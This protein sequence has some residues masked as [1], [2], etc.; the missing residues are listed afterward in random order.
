MQKFSIALVVLCLPGT[1]WTATSLA[2]DGAA[3]RG[4]IVQS[5]HKG[6]DIP[7]QELNT[8]LFEQVF[9]PDPPLPANWKDMQVEQRQAWIKEFEESE[10]GKQFLANNEKLLDK[11]QV[12]DVKIDDQGEFAVYDVPPG[13]YALR[14]RVDKEMNKRNFAFEIFGE[15]KVLKDVDELLLDPIMVTVTPLLVAGESAPEFSLKTYDNSATLVPSQFRGKYVFLNFWSTESSPSVEFQ[16]EIQKMYTRLQS[17][18]PLELLSVNVDTNR[19]TAIEHIKKAKLQ[20]RHGFTDGWDH[21]TLQAYGVRAIPSQWLLDPEGK[22]LMTNMDFRRAFI[23]GKRDLATIVDDRIEGKDVPTP[24]D[25]QSVQ[26]PAPSQ[27]DKQAEP[28][29]ATR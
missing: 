5:S 15:V 16:A 8:Q 20:G 27:P 23:A 28:G 21:S 17:K 7:L 11:A 2:R 3:I 4:K 14:G 18:H 6:F 10:K 19:K 9:L 25:Q 29:K 26:P 12:Y 22:I 13:T 24:A 1:A